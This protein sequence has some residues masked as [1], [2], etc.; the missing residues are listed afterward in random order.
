[1]SE[2]LS[3]DGSRALETLRTLGFR[4]DSTTG[5]H[6]LLRSDGSQAQLYDVKGGFGINSGRLANISD[7]SRS[8]AAIAAVKLARAVLKDESDRLKLPR[9]APPSIE[10]NPY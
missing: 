5:S 3:P 6:R 1:M 4:L 7:L 9:W 2:T 8:D 10:S